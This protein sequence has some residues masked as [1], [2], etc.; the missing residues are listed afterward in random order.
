MRLRLRSALFAACLLSATAAHALTATYTASGAKGADVVIE[1][2][3]DKLRAGTVP[4]KGGYL[5]ARDQRIYAISTKGGRQMVMDAVQMIQLARQTGLVMGGQLPDIDK[6]TGN[7]GS[8]VRLSD[9]QRTETVGGI[10]GKVYELVYADREGKERKVDLVM[11]R[12][13][14]L[15]AM[16][17]QLL[18]LAQTLQTAA[19][20]T[21]QD[22]IKQLATEIRQR[23]LGL[24]RVGKDLTLKHLDLADVADQRFTLPKG[25]ANLQGLKGLFK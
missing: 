23:Q 19:S 22:S 6:Y 15:A 17:S 20:D 14:A 3:Q 21:D 9:T 5:I 1:S 10:A 4:D 18:D 11:T 16:T 12:N 25:G 24:L 8:F 13:A 2:S 7:I